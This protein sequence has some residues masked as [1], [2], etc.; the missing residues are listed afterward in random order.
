MH[1]DAGERMGGGRSAGGGHDDGH[2]LRAGR[3]DEHRGR[4]TLR[5]AT[6]GR[7]V[8]S[9]TGAMQTKAG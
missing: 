8:G 3:A 1:A 5:I 9:G 7:A 4:G 6:F 2:A